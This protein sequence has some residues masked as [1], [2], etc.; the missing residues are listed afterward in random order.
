MENT[1]ISSC[2]KCYIQAVRVLLGY[3]ISKSIFVEYKLATALGNEEFMDSGGTGI[4]VS[5]EDGWMLNMLASY[6]VFAALLYTSR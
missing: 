2:N 6:L 4:S 1:V 5:H 3:N